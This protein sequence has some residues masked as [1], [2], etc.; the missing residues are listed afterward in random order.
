MQRRHQWKNR[1]IHE[2]DH[3]T[4]KG[5]LDTLVVETNAERTM[6]RTHPKQEDKRIEGLNKEQTHDKQK[7]HKSYTM[8]TVPATGQ[9]AIDVSHDMFYGGGR[10]HVIGGSQPASA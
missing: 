4:R 5:T 2:A 10:D 7:H 3:K 9:Q 6:E 8:T 1:P